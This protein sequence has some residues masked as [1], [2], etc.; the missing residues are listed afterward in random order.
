MGKDKD[1]MIIEVRFPKS[2]KTLIVWFMEFVPSKNITGDVGHRQILGKLW[3]EQIEALV[4]CSPR[5]YTG[6]TCP[7]MQLKLH[8]KTRASKKNQ[9]EK[10]LRNDKG[11]GTNLENELLDAGICWEGTSCKLRIQHELHHVHIFYEGKRIKRPKK[12]HLY[13]RRQSAFREAKREEKYHCEKE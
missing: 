13:P 4:N 9:K 12:S 10:F 7:N 2:K 5:V 1:T 8:E 6:T 3:E 11:K